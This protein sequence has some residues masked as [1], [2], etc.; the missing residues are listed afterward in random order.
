MN[1]AHIADMWVLYNRYGV[2]QIDLAKQYDIPKRAVS[3]IVN[4][5]NKHK[6]WK[7]YKRVFMSKRIQYN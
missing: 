6:A 7:R 3:Y 2:T 4:A 1:K 5:E